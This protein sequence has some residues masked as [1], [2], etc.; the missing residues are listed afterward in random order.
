MR[1]WLILF[2]ACFA[3]SAYAQTSTSSTGGSTI[4]ATITGVSVNTTTRTVSVTVTSTFTNAFGLRG[5]VWM[6]LTNSNA[7]PSQG[8]ADST[9]TSPVVKTVNFTYPA[10]GTVTVYLGTYVFQTSGDNNKFDSKSQAIVYPAG[11]Q[12]QTVVITPGTASLLAGNSQVFTASGGHTSY[13]WSLSGGGALAY[14][15]ASAT[16]QAT[17]GGTYTL[18]VYAPAGTGWLRSNDA[19][20]TITS[21]P[22][23]RVRVSLKANTG[24]WPIEYIV[25]Q[26]GEA[27]ATYTQAPGASARIISQVV[28]TTDPVTVLSRQIGISQEETGTWSVNP[29]GAGPTTTSPAITPIASDEPPAVD[30]PAPAAPA[31]PA[32]T[33]G[34]QNFK[35]VWSSVTP[36]TNP[37][38]QT[39]LLTN[40]TFREGVDKQVENLAALKA[41]SDKREKEGDDAKAAGDRW[42]GGE[43]VTEF[44][45][46]AQSKLTAIASTDADKLSSLAITSSTVAPIAKA[47]TIS[48]GADIVSGLP[49]GSFKLDPLASFPWLETMLTVIREIILWGMGWMFYTAA[50]KKLERIQFALSMVPQ[51]DVEPGEKIMLFGTQIPGSASAISLLKRAFVGSVIIGTIHIQI[52][53]AITALNSRMGEI[54]GGWSFSSIG[55]IGAAVSTASGPMGTAF[56]IMDLVFPINA[57]IMYI[58]AWGLFAWA[59]MIIY[60]VASAA[61]K[62]IKI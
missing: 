44:W 62:A 23:N 46:A 61:I 59:C 47:S 35:P 3:V 5:V 19:T 14:D 32:P 49:N 25:M 1:F 4:T 8:V 40:S 12:P 31:A 26:Q 54:F 20:A 53:A 29:E 37:A 6:G 18:T 50:Q 33:Q 52:A 24:S 43:A 11:D 39:D 2:F 17:N 21:T 15:G 55:N 45:N 42:M 58:V 30:L 38:N 34:A 16:V 48:L 7:I 13:V 10:G 51:V 57:S 27:V 56:R 60:G 9:Q 22:S 28:A 36:N 41:T